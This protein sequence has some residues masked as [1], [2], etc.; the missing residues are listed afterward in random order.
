MFDLEFYEFINILGFVIGIVFGA[1]AQKTQF[2]F[3][4]SIK[5]FI[6]M[7]STRRASS[8]VFAMIVA[9]IGTAIV[10]S[11]YDIDLGESQYLREN[12]NYFSIILGGLMF[13]VGMMLADGCSNRHLI[14]FAQGDVNSLITIVFIGIFALATSK[15]Y[16]YGNLLWFTNNETLLEYSSYIKNNPINIYLVLVL[17]VGI[18]LCLLKRIK[19]VVYLYD[20][21][22]IGILV[23][24][25]WYVTGVIAEDSFE[26]VIPLSSIS[27][28][29]PTSKTLELFGAYEVNEFTFP[30]AIVC[31]IVFGAFLMSKIN[32]KYSFG[33]ASAGGK[34]RIK[35]NMIGGALMGTGG[36]LSLG[37]TVGQ[38]ITGISTLA[39][40]SFLA[41]LSIL[42]SAIITA[43]ILNKKDKLP[44]CFIFEW[45]DN[46]G[47]YQI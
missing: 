12:I 23:S 4:G 7:K 31:G 10:S 27:F 45:S 14:K 21:L 41:I 8:V 24:F 16:I 29:Y 30:I 2:C 15:G 6:L 9:I 11:I 40:A 35:Y 37:C 25:T 33:C 34:N 39:F 26:R 42:F 38:G 28:V 17:L 47:E 13:G 32:K 18:L 36:I 43:L 46:R 5:D 1:V 20:G 44:M 22:I 3:S 19:R